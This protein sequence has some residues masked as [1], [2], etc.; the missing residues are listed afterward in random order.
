MKKNHE[1]FNWRN[2][3]YFQGTCQQLT[4][5]LATFKWK[6][7]EK[8]NQL[9]PCVFERLTNNNNNNN[10]LNINEQQRKRNWSFDN[11]FQLSMTFVVK[12]LFAFWWWLATDFC[13]VF[14]K[15][16]LAC[17]Y[18]THHYIHSNWYRFFSN[19]FESNRSTDLQN[20]SLNF[21]FKNFKI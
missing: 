19:S 14:Q 18:I 15:A 9:T 17:W 13:L 8:I 10:R 16:I 12:R 3:F 20:V 11:F 7:L 2:K 21:F 6:K 4:G 1:L 5:W